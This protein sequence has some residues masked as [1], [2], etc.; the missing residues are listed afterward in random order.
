MSLEDYIHR[1]WMRRVIDLASLGIGDTSPNPLV[2]AVILD[3]T[4]RLISEGFHQK[5][6]MPHAEA[7][8]FNNL[9]ED[10]R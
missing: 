10:P 7:M 5:A 1:K 8:A 4:G 9:K 2:G 6:G 3:K